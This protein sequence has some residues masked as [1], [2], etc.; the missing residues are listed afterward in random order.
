MIKFQHSN[1][2]SDSTTHHS[3]VGLADLSEQELRHV[4]GGVIPAPV[5]LWGVV[6][7]GALLDECG[8]FD[9]IDVGA[10]LESMN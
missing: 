3:T 10:M 4:S 7:A 9:A 5:V 8:A 1:R 2:N 6:I